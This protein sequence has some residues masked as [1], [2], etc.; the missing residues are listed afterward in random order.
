MK[1]SIITVCYN[2]EQYIRSTMESV[3]AQDYS[4]IEYIVVD[5]SSTDTTIDIV[6][7]YEPLF[8]GRM[9]WISEK[10]NG[11]YDAMNKGIAMASG[12]IIG[13]LNSD[14]LFASPDSVEKIIS[15]FDEKGVDCM[16]ADLYYVS[17]SDTDKIIRH[18]QSGKRKDFSKGWHPA[19]PTF[20]VNK[21]VYLQFGVFNLTYK[22]AADFE[23]MLRLIEKH[24][25]SIWYLPEVL[26]KMRL[27]GTTNKS[28]KNIIKGNIECYK[29]FKENSIQVSIIYPLFRIFPKTMQFFRKK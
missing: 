23:L 7:A 27:G 3:L 11:I 13:I 15:V 5:G 8:Y 19:H 2:S 16:Y 25:I 14:D 20:Y 4:D 17:Q 21:N 9:K 1:V 26:I 10:D 28:L 6:K 29:A 18:W 12:D 22:F 24:N